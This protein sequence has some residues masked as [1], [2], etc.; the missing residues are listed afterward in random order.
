MK[1]DRF[2]SWKC[3]AASLVVAGTALLGSAAPS[4]AFAAPAADHKKEFL[5]NA[6]NVIGAGQQ[7]TAALGAYYNAIEQIFAGEAAHGGGH[8]AHGGSHDSHDDAHGEPD[9]HRGQAPCDPCTPVCGRSSLQ[10]TVWAVP[11]YTHQDAF[12]LHSGGIHYGYESDQYAVVFGTEVK[13]GHTRFGI[14]GNVGIGR[15]VSPEHDAHTNSD[16]TFGGVSLYAVR[17]IGK[18]ESSSQIGWLGT[19]NDVRQRNDGKLAQADIDG[20]LMFAAVGFERPYHCGHLTIAPLFGLEYTHLYQQ[21]FATTGGADDFAA[22][23]SEAD[24][25]HIPVG[26]KIH[27]SHKTSLGHWSPSI[28]ARALPHVGAHGLN[29]VNVAAGAGTHYHTHGVASDVVAGDVAFGSMLKRGHSEIGATYTILF[30]EHFT[31]QNVNLV[32]KRKF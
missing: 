18:I 32:V 10:R 27:A 21:S 13:S 19:R 26:L 22:G 12:N 31:S 9:A 3:A 15:V 11:I 30:S 7:G 5:A 2:V 24:M 20:G 17:H 8:G 6:A 28:K 23:Y 14:A 1:Q 4:S 29:F 25:L 16:L